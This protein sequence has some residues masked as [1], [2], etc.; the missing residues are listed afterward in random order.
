MRYSFSYKGLV[1]SRKN[2]KEKKKSLQRYR[3][4]SDNC[5][6]NKMFVSKNDRSKWSARPEFDR[7][8]PQSGRTSSVDRPLFSALLT[9]HDILLNLIQ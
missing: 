1:Q 8:S 9:N 4:L 5:M 7:S 2:A 6:E 3:E